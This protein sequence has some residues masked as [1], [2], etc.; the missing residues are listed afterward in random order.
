VIRQHFFGLAAAIATALLLLGCAK[1]AP[2]TP[3]GVTPAGYSAINTGMTYEEAAEILGSPDS[4]S[5]DQSGEARTVDWSDGGDGHISAIFMRNHLVAKNQIN[6]Q[7]GASTDLAAKVHAC[8]AA[9]SSCSDSCDAYWKQCVGAPG[10]PP[11]Q[12]CNDDLDACQD[13]CNR[14][15]LQCRQ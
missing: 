10:T 12:H 15:L 5:F 1:P 11:P 4:S 2:T 7:P 8:Q 6:V 14:Q 9:A 3:L 13:S